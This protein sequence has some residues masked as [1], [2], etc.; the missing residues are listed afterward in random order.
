MEKKMRIK[1][2]CRLFYRAS[3]LAK[4]SN[5]IKR[6]AAGAHRP[7]WPSEPAKRPDDR[8]DSCLDCSFLPQCKHQVLVFTLE[9]R[10]ARPMGEKWWGLCPMSIPSKLGHL[11]MP[12]N[13]LAQG[14]NQM[15]QAS[16]EPGTSR[17]SRYGVLRSAVAPHWLGALCGKSENPTTSVCADWCFRSILPSSSSIRW[18]L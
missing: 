5:R 3:V 2:V 13:F 7:H 8:A 12:I 18:I 15:A 17:S 9:W 1:K 16:F 4:S 14:K 10:E 11:A 6:E